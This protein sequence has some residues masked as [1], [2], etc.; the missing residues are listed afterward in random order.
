[1]QTSE[2]IV[3][4]ITKMSEDGKLVGDSHPN[5]RYSDHEVELMRQLR[6]GGMK[7]VDIAR[8]FGC[9]RAQAGKVVNYTARRS[10]AARIRFSID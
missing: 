1:L 5:A 4:K 6:E 3:Q 8:R 9:S 2:A 10:V 7:I